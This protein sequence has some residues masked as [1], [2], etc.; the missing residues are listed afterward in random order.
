MGRGRGGVASN[1]STVCVQTGVFLSASHISQPFRVSQKWK[2][3]L[4]C[5]F[6]L[7]TVWIDVLVATLEASLCCYCYSV[8]THLAVRSE[9]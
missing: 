8:S 1:Q 3:C 7:S 2:I 4:E 9:P 6:S 5:L